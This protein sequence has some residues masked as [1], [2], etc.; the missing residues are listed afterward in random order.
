MALPT[1]AT[2]AVTVIPLQFLGIKRFFFRKRRM[3]TFIHS[4]IVCYLYTLLHNQSSMSSNFLVDDISGGGGRG[5][6]L[7]P[8]AFQLL[9]LS[10]TVSSYASIN[11]QSLQLITFLIDLLAISRRFLSRFLKFSFLLWSLF[12]WLAALILLLRCFSFCLLHLMS[13]ML[14]VIIY[15][16]SNFWF[17]WFGLECILVCL[18]GTC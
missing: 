13:D 4:S 14:I 7:R 8:A 10:S 11:Y 16:L 15:L 12:S 1:L 17:N 18:F 5:S 3:Q 9:I 2:I 6:L